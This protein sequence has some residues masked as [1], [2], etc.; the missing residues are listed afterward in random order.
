MKK[1]WIVIGLNE[2]KVVSSAWLSSDGV[3]VNDGYYLI[4]KTIGTC[5]TFVE[6][7]EIAESNMSGFEYVEIK[8]AFKVSK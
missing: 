3:N 8:E 4:G 7:F 5:D 6:A 2:E 1:V